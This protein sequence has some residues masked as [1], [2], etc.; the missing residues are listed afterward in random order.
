MSTFVSIRGVGRDDRTE[1][2][3]KTTL[4]NMLTGCMSQAKAGWSSMASLWPRASLHLCS[5]RSTAG[6]RYADCGSRRLVVGVILSTASF[7]CAYHRRHA[8]PVPY[9]MDR[10][11]IGVGI[12]LATA[13]RRR[14]NHRVASLPVRSERYF[15]NL[16]EYSSLWRSDRAGECPHRILSSTPYQPVRCFFRTGGWSMKRKRTSRGPESCWHGSICRALRTNAPRICPTR[17]A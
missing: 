1:R 11:L 6:R 10:V 13:S 2:A 14:R 16:P 3:G 12:S 5:A 9:C 7:L 15:A 17:S 8:S 4:F